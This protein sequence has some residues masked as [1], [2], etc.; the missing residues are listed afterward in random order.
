MKIGI[1]TQP[2]RTNYGGILQ[3]YAL[4]TILKRRGHTVVTLGRESL[5]RV[6]YPRYILTLTKRFFLKCFGKYSGSLFREK[7]YNQDYPIFT[8]H[9]LRFVKERI[10]HT[11]IHDFSKELSHKDYDAYIVGSD[12]VWRP[13]Y[14]KIENMFLDFTSGWNVK[15]VAYAASFGTDDWEFSKE[16]TETCQNLIKKFDAVSIR[17]NSGIKLCKDYLHA[18]AIHVLDPT[19]L[20]Q[21]Q[22]RQKS[23]PARQNIQVTYTY[24]Q[25]LYIT[26]ACAM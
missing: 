1:I 2:L 20:L 22:N 18:D 8:Q 19:M 12:Q 15:R 9:T 16:Q 4:Q 11:E 3:N 7:K 21:K 17:E 24:R 23:L 6:K 14:N 25:R 5:I 26:G 10:H 13:S